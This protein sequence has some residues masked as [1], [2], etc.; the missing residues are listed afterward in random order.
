MPAPNNISPQLIERTFQKLPDNIKAALA[1][2]G[3]DIIAIGQSH[4]LSGSQILE[5]SFI[6]L[7]IF[8]GNLAYQEL[9]KE[10]KNKLNLPEVVAKS[11][12]QEIRNKLLSPHADFLKKVHAEISQKDTA[13]ILSKQPTPPSNLP[14][15]SNQDI[16]PKNTNIQ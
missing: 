4:N 16:K 3:A 8:T 9:E 2:N 5:I 15:A 12:A 6:I 14:Q 10:V 13:K 7:K 11:T 1:D